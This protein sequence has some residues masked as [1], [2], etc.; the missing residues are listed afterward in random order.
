MCKRFSFT[1]FL[2]LAT[3]PAVQQDSRSPKTM[4]ISRFKI[5]MF[6]SPVRTYRHLC[7]FFS[8][9]CPDREV[10]IYWFSNTQYV[11][12]SHLQSFHFPAEGT[13]LNC[14]RFE[15]LTFYT[16]CNSWA[17]LHTIGMYRVRIILN[18]SLICQKY[19]Y[20]IYKWLWKVWRIYAPKTTD[21]LTF[22]TLFDEL[23]LSA[24]SSSSYLSDESPFPYPS[25]EFESSPP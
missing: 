21:R 12:L 19:I 11:R 3:S 7:R 10:S 23:Y 18:S 2:V 1:M 5:R 16:P 9:K 24:C 6:L 17:A 25:F 8:I 13:P 4:H 15:S 22:A 14:T 20:K